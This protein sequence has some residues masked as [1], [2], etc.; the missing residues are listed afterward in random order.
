MMRAVLYA[1][2]SSETQAKQSTVESQVEA[3]RARACQDGMAIRPDQ[4]YVD[5]GVSGGTLNR[6]ALDR[7][8]DAAADG[9][10]DVL[11]VLA[12]DRLARKFAHQAL[13]LEEFSRWG[14]R[15]V[16]LNQ[17]AAEGPEGELLVQVQGVIAEYEKA[18]ILERS[19]RGKLH[20]ARQGSVSVLSQAPYGYVYVRKAGQ[21]S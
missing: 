10:V 21:E 2:V 17:A 19:R 6:P 8:M 1:R 11:Y 16:F 9:D 3:L 18:K 14:V 13:L 20:K 5:D 12:P 4:E 15:V 7:L